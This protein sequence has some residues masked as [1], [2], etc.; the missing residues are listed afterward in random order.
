MYIDIS[1]N[2]K[3]AKFEATP[4]IHATTA[5]AATPMPI[6]KPQISF[7]AKGILP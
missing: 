2:E 6:I 4:R 1:T 3:I 7:T 5:I